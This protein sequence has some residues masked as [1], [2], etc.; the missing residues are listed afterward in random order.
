MEFSS[1]PPGTEGL[2]S[3]TPFVVRGSGARSAA[4]STTP[5]AGQSRSALPGLVASSRHWERVAR[6]RVSWT[7][8]L[9]GWG[10]IV[11]SIAAIK[12]AS[13]V[14]TSGAF[15]SVVTFFGATWIP[16]VAGSLGASGLV[17]T[18]FATRGLR[19]FSRAWLNVFRTA[20]VFAGIASLGLA[21]AAVMGVAMA[22]FGILIAVALVAL[23]IGL[24]LNA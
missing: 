6:A 2:G 7:T 8:T 24:L 13:I 23:I 9:V 5:S 4:R 1:R 15:G 3:T 12:V 17:V 22:V 21:A 20:C 18:V 14:E 11:S 16:Y 19:A 10:L